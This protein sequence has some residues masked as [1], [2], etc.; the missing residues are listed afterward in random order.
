MLCKRRRRG[1]PTLGIATPAQ[2]RFSKTCKLEGVVSGAGKED[3]AIAG[4]GVCLQ[5]QGALRRGIFIKARECKKRTS[6]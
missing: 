4:F 2:G 5:L 1:Y 6:F 3:I